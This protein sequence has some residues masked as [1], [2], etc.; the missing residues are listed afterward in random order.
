MELSEK[1]RTAM[2]I[3]LLAVLGAFIGWVYEM[4]F[5]RIDVGHFIKRGHG[6]GPW[7][8]IYAFGALALIFL[9]YKRKLHPALL[10]VLSVI[11]SGVIEYVT[12]WVLYH[13]M[14]GV[15]LWDYNTEIW[16]WGNIGGF[17]CFRSVLVFGIFGTVFGIFV[18]PNFLKWIQKVKAFPLVVFTSVLAVVVFLDLVNGYIIMPIINGGL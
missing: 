11:S 13:L 10:F 6:F 8:P 18:V 14:G 17:V 3:F 1:K 4:L 15:R 5:Y 2:G 9:V 7:L 12:G 16:N